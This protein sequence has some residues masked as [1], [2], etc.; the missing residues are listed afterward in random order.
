ML[1]WRYGAGEQQGS[2][3]NTLHDAFPLS[4]INIKEENK[5][6]TMQHLEA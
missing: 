6:S 2:P 4:Q 5:M 1:S 3:A